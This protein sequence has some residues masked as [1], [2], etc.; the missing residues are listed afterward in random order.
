MHTTSWAFHWDLRA[1]AGGNNS[2]KATKV[3]KRYIFTG[4]NRNK[5]LKTTV[6]ALDFPA[7]VQRILSTTFGSF[8]SNPG[9]DHHRVAG[10]WHPAG[11]LQA[12]EADG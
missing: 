4:Q 11:Q 12:T 9:E 10:S 6:Q 8:F 2:V 1:M 5:K 3:Q 7:P